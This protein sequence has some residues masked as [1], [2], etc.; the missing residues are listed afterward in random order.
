MY[1]HGLTTFVY[2]LLQYFVNRGSNCITYL[3]IKINDEILR[4]GYYVK[5][6]LTLVDI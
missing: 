5:P 2:Y 1:L 4:N 6:N 3:Q